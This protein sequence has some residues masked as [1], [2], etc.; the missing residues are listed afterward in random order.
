MTSTTGP[1]P[2]PFTTVTSAVIPSQPCT[3]SMVSSNSISGCPVDDEE[4]CGA[5][6]NGGS[7]SSINTADLSIS[8]RVIAHAPMTAIMTIR[9]PICPMEE[10]DEEEDPKGDIKTGDDCQQSLPRQSRN[11]RKNFKPRNIV[12]QYNADDEY[13]TD[14]E[15][16]DD[17]QEFARS[18]PSRNSP[19]SPVPSRSFEGERGQG[20]EQPLDLSSDTGPTR[21]K[22]NPKVHGEGSP[23]MNSGRSPPQIPRFDSCEYDGE[24]E[25]SAM[26]EDRGR[27]P[28][29]D[30]SRPSNRDGTGSGSSPSHSLTGR[31]I[32][33]PSSPR[34]VCHQDYP[35]AKRL[36][37]EPPLIPSDG[38]TMKDYAENTMKELLGMYG[39]NDAPEGLSSHLPIH[40]FSAGECIFIV[41]KANPLN[42]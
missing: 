36:T 31:T 24:D 35:Q 23:R 2:P 40:N 20:G 38:T 3:P 28:V 17:Q 26:D 29:M 14:E 19:S 32:E 37:R 4:P 11:K 30:L 10:D 9:S 15:C 41:F 39:L 18:S 34:L 27:T 16:F 7:P 8:P 22:L 21:W 42:T 5:L 13:G 25:G 1:S 6:M 33:S 12:Y